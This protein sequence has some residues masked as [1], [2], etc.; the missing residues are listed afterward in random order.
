MRNRT[1]P[2]AAALILAV[3]LV[4]GCNNDENG[5]GG[6]ATPATAAAP[7]PAPP[8]ASHALTIKMSEF[9]FTPKDATAASGKVTITAPNAGKAPHELVVLKTDADPAKLPKKGGEVDEA[10][11]VGEVSPVKAGQSG[12]HVFKLKPGKYAMVCNLPGHYAAGMYG[13]LTVK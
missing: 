3:P 2:I 12:K 4:A 6:E 8:A 5:P 13:S 1:L 10:A 9:A 7:P 11:S